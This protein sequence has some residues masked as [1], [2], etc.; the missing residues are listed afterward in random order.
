M[1]QVGNKHYPYTKE[2]MAAAAAARRMQAGGMTDRIA[3][4]SNPRP[5]LLGGPR[6]NPV[7]DLALEKIRSEFPG[8][9]R[10][11]ALRI[12]HKRRGTPI[13]GSVPDATTG[14]KYFNPVPMPGSSRWQRLKHL[15]PAHATSPPPAP[16]R[17][18]VGMQEG[19]DS[20]YE[21]RI[22]EL[23]NASHPITGQ[24]GGWVT[25][26]MAEDTLRR[27]LENGWD[28]DGDGIVSAE[29]L[30]R[31]QQGETTLDPNRP[32]TSIINTGASS[33]P[34]EDRINEL[35][36]EHKGWD[37]KKAEDWQT[38]ALNNNWDINNDGSVSRSE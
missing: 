12:Y 17:R 24:P 34:Y 9:N 25:R 37:R 19:G 6:R 28:F 36:Q 32:S 5:P 8:I 11:Q 29:E 21:L 26:E 7:L 35:M 20:A 10:Q 13:D 15:P 18:P 14:G 33:G 27:G 16:P 38:G 3:G 4:L 1:P 23:M 22:A 2:G 30:T 31:G